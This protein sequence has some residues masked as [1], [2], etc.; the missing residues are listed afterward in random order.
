MAVPSFPKRYMTKKF[1]DIQ[2]TKQKVR[3]ENHHREST[4]RRVD[5]PNKAL[6]HESECSVMH[7]NLAFH[8]S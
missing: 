1:I 5:S 4:P 2:E 6:N 3:T 8:H 7:S